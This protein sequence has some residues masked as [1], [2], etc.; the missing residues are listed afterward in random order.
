MARK[1]IATDPFAVHASILAGKRPPLEIM[2]EAMYWLAARAREDRPI[3][4]GTGAGTKTY[5]PPQLH[6]MAADVAAKVAP[7]VYPKLANVQVPQRAG[8]I[9]DHLKALAI[10]AIDDGMPEPITEGALP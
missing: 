7:F 3:T 4:V 10:E 1:L 8:G 2:L 6:L 5:D 9:E